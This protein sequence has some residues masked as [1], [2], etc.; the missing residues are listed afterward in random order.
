MV[1]R[2]QTSVSLFLDSSILFT[3]VNSPTGGSSKLFALKDIRL[4]TSTY[5]LTETEMNVRKK[6]EE[7]H[8][9]RFFRLVEK[10]E[11]IS[12]LPERKEL[13]K[14]KKVIVEKDAI[15]L[16]QVKLSRSKFLITLDKKHFLTESVEKYLKPKKALTTKMF[17]DW[18]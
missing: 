2:R 14:A 4:L 13:T 18:W 16:S 17:F 10:L 12:S 8:L 1:G 15:I 7:Y 3:A 5:V 11:I 9:E 6:L